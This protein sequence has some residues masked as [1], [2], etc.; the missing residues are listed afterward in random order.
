MPDGIFG[1]D[2]ARTAPRWSFQERQV[3]VAVILFIGAAILGLVVAT[4]KVALRRQWAMAVTVGV[5]AIGLAYLYLML[6][7]TP[8][9]I[10]VFGD[11]RLD[12]LP[13]NAVM[14]TAQEL[15]ALF[16]DQTHSGKYFERR[17]WYVYRE[18]NSPDGQ[19]KGSG[20]PTGN[21]EAWNRS[22]RWKIEGGEIC[23]DYNEGYNCQ[24]IYRVGAVYKQTDDHDKVSSEF[25]VDTDSP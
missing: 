16:S 13:D 15:E 4:V 12:D 3:G 23:R 2:T 20:G 24:P 7:G 25:T 9:W 21:P 5:P 6:A 1:N 18:S 14:V 19:I 10:V 11:P 17:T 22:G 8:L